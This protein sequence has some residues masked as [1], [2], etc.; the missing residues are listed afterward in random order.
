M[1]KAIPYVLLL[2]LALIVL[3]TQCGKEPD[4]VNITDDRFLNALIENGV[5]ANVD[6]IISPAEA[7]AIT[8][9]DVSLD[10][11]SDMTGIEAF[12]NLENLDCREN[13]L[14]SLIE[15]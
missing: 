8:L 4:L 5:D 2:L 12:V 7:E 1:M 10:S 11:I 15:P 6:G 14:T 9:L 3:F 13:N